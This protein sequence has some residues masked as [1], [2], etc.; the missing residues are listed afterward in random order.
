MWWVRADVRP[1]TADGVRATK[2]RHAFHRTRVGVLSCVLLFQTACTGDG[3]SGSSS[4]PST[5]AGPTATATTP[6]D[7]VPEAAETE[8]AS[9]P[10]EPL[11]S[12]SLSGIATRGLAAYGTLEDLAVTRTGTATLAWTDSVDSGEIHTMDD[13]AA[14]GDPQ[15]PAGPPDPQHRE[16]FDALVTTSWMSMQRA[17]KRCSGSRTS[18]VRE[19]DRLRSRSSSTSRSRTGARVPRG[20]VRRRCSAPG[21]SAV[22][23]WR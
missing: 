2:G 7:D 11:R 17:R 21:T 9:C 22:V 16:V 5:A 12:W 19:P 20:P 10:S 4:S 18:A 8:P 1:M 13:P 23:S 3:S 14:P 15:S 6:S